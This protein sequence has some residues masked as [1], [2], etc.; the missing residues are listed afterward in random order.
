[1][2][3]SMKRKYESTLQDAA[4]DKVLYEQVDSPAHL[5]QMMM[6]SARKIQPMV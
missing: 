3:I 1:M 4:T 5:I 6:Q 2:Y